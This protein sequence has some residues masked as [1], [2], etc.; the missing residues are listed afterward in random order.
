M[1]VMNE[2]SANVS[3]SHEFMIRQMSGDLH[4]LSHSLEPRKTCGSREEHL[5][6]SEVSIACCKSSKINQSWSLNRPGGN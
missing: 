5:L 3:S 1:N 6:T 2:R 4:I